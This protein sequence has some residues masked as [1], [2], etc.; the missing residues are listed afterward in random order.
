MNKY[1][2]PSID[3]LS[4][5]KSFK[6][7][8]TLYLKDLLKKEKN[9]NQYKVFLGLNDKEKVWIDL[10]SD[11]G[12]II[13]GST[14]SGKSVFIDSILIT[15]LMKNS[16]SDLRLVLMDSKIV[17]LEAYRN[18]PHNLYDVATNS[19]MALNYL[20]NIKEELEYRKK[21]FKGQKVINFSNYNG[22][23][24]FAKIPL[25]LLVVDETCNVFAD[26]EVEKLL[27]EIIENGY[28]YGI[29]VILSTNIIQKDYIINK[30]KSKVD[31][32]ISFDLS[33][34][35]DSKIVGTEG[36][37]LLSIG[38]MIASSDEGIKKIKAPYISDKDIKKVTKYIISKNK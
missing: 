20:K 29:N 15:L 16:P 25:I 1:N 6:L 19:K 18:L 28:K 17:E 26:N 21:I 12:I 33:C 38:E 36:A 31:Y 24:R 27:L 34:K 13:T 9:D 4:S 23:N 8:N 2:Y 14:G 7:D 35:Q 3:L 5:K 22:K 32:K 11:Y 30:L 37:E 10:A